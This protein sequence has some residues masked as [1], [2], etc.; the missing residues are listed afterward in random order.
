VGAKLSNPVSD[1]WALFTQFGLTFND[2]DANTGDPEIGGNMLFQPILPVPVYGE[3][4][5]KWQLLV[6][7]TIPIFFG[8]PV[9]EGFDRFETFIK[10]HLGEI[11]EADFFTVEVLTLVGLLRY[12]VFFV[13]DIP[14][15]KVNIA[16]ILHQPH[17]RWMEQIARNL[18]DAEDGSCAASGT[19]SSTAIRSTLRHSAASCGIR[20]AVKGMCSRLDFS[21]VSSRT[22]HVASADPTLLSSRARYH[23]EP[24]TPS[25][26]TYPVVDPA[27]FPR[28]RVDRGTS[29]W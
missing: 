6:R 29:L 26:L 7:P 1:V 24:C 16:G 21:A 22:A 2:G 3:G 23:V 14:T 15:R 13:I 12:Y 10:A 18:T 27:Q 19:C 28:E 4:E 25:P 8:N 17:G 11:A 20:S 9:S 5:E